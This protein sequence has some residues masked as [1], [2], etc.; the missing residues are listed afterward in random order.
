LTPFPDQAPT[1]AYLHIPFCRQKCTYCDFISFAAR[2]RDCQ[3]AYVAALLREI[4]IVASNRLYL[5]GRK[6]V[7]L[8]T[9][10]VGGGTPTVLPAG[11]LVRLLGQ[12]RACFG[13]EPDCECTVEANP[14]TVS[15]EALETL[16]AAGFNR[17]SFGL[18]AVQP[19]LLHLLGRIHEAGD[20]AT[21]V[22]AARSAGFSNINVDLLFGLPGQ[23]IQDIDETLDFVLGLP[24]TH[25]SFYG[26]ILEEGTPLAAAEARGQVRLPDDDL[27]RRQYHR[28]RL[29]L[30]EQGFIHYEISNSARPG[31]ACRHNLVYWQALPYY[32]FGLAAHSYTDGLRLA[33]PSDMDRYLTAC[34]GDTAGPAGW[35][36]A[37][38]SERIDRQEAM[39]ETM[40]LGLRLIRGVRARDFKARFGISLFERFAV[41]LADLHRRGLIIVSGG[42]VRLS[43]RGLD[44]ANQAFRAFIGA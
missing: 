19:R 10:F 2:G 18:Q 8:Q 30:A 21:G 12:L 5:P 25:I 37:E 7:P 11:D 23:T 39:R 32:G 26:L 28:I 14:G 38:V 22:Q 1:A 40:L 6:P 4:E 41:P 35:P 34:R 16:Y 29:R 17:I 24:V 13:M 20:L 33:N 9:V 27:E 42:R 36:C 3:Q 15:Q 43:R 44:L 31:Y